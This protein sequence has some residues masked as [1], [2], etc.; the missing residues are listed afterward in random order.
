MAYKLSR[1]LK[2][3]L[4]LQLGGSYS[5]LGEKYQPGKFANRFSGNTCAP[6]TRETLKKK[7]SY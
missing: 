1:P 5:S 4:F 3:D 2:T 7:K 6:K